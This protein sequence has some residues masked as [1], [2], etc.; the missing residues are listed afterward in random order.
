MRV[1]E[2]KL[3]LPRAA[4]Y[5]R[6]STILENQEDSFE[7]QK[8]HFEKLLAKSNIYE[9]AGIYSDYGI[10]GTAERTLH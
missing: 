9:N 4:A 10:S 3:Q 1:K 8:K 6:V 5:I 2:R 7:N